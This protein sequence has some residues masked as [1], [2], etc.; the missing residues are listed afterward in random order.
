M[1]IFKSLI[2]WYF[3]RSNKTNA[4]WPSGTILY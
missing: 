4:W 1:K 3:S 2:N